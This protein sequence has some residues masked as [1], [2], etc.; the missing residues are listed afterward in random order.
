MSATTAVQPLAIEDRFAVTDVVLR[1]FRLVDQGRAG[2]TAAL[3]TADATLTFGPGAP[4]PGTIAGADIPAAMAARQAQVHV[5]TRHVLSNV[6]L[7]PAEDGSVH[8]YSLLT[9][10]RSEDEKRDSDPASVADIDDVL[11][12]DG[13]G[14]R[15]KQRTITPVFNRG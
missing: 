7:S 6:V 13:N 11:V 15:I 1:F 4:K 9:L 5:T 12:R 8:V 10:F 3:F 14:W 2:E